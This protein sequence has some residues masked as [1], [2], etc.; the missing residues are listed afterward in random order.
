MNLKNY[1]NMLLN[2]VSFSYYLDSEIDDKA[3]L[4]EKKITLRNSK[5]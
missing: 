1:A 4:Y 5:I 2:W 3:D